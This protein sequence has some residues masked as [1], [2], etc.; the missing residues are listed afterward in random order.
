M[1][2]DS[3]INLLKVEEISAIKIDVEGAELMVLK[4]MEKSIEKYRPYLYIEILFTKNQEDIDR[5][6]DICNFILEMNY[7]ILGVNLTSQKTEIITN[8]NK[9]GKNY[10]C[11]YVFA[12]NEHLENFVKTMK[13]L[14]LHSEPL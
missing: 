13:K 7:S 3:L 14:Q 9:V 4:G 8:L 5:A 2:G 12:P 1:T 6:M 10:D 11:N